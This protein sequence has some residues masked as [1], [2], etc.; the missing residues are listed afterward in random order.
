[1]YTV[2]ILAQASSLQLVVCRAVLYSTTT[3]Y[4]FFFIHASIC[5]LVIFFLSNY[6]FLSLPCVHL[7]AILFPLPSF[8]HFSPPACVS[9][10][11]SCSFLCSLLFFSLSFPVYFSAPPHVMECILCKHVVIFPCPWF[12]SSVLLDGSAGQ[13]ES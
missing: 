4:T 12:S 13:C 3:F 11:I 6:K 10:H 9:L 8:L 2:T 1:M 7:T 5:V